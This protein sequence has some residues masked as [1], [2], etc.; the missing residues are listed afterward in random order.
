MSKS[1][2]L[3]ML[4]IRTQ[5]ENILIPSV[6][7][8]RSNSRKSERTVDD[9]RSFDSFGSLALSVSLSAGYVA[10]DH[11][12]SLCTCVMPQTQKVVKGPTRSL[13]S[14]V[15]MVGKN[16][17]HLD[18]PV[19]KEE[20]PSK[21]DILE[22]MLPRA[23][24]NEQ[25]AARK[26]LRL[27]NESDQ[28]TLFN[29]LKSSKAGALVSSNLSV[30]S[31]QPVHYASGDYSAT[32]SV[33]SEVENGVEPRGIRLGSE[34]EGDF[35]PISQRKPSLWATSEYNGMYA[36]EEFKKKVEEAEALAR[37]AEIA[38]AI[39][40]TK[41]QLKEKTMQKVKALN[42]VLVNKIKL[43]DAIEASAANL[44]QLPH[45]RQKR[46][47]G[48]SDYAIQ[49]E[50]L[51][52][53]LRNPALKPDEEID[54]AA[55]ERA[56]MPVFKQ[57]VITVKHN[58][59]DG[60]DVSY[61]SKEL[62][63]HASCFSEADSLSSDVLKNLQDLGASEIK[64][65]LKDLANYINSH[66]SRKILD[67]WH[68]I[69]GRFR[70]STHS[71]SVIEIDANG[72]AHPVKHPAIPLS[73]L[74]YM[75]CSTKIKVGHEELKKMC[76]RLGF[77]SQEQSF[78]AR[79][80][81][82]VQVVLAM[83]D[84]VKSE[85]YE[86]FKQELWHLSKGGE[87]L[88]S[89]QEFTDII[90]PDD[91]VERETQM[92]IIKASRQEQVQAMMDEKKNKATMKHRA[93]A[94]KKQMIDDFTIAL[95]QVQLMRG[96]LTPAKVAEFT[97]M[98]EKC[99]DYIEKQNEDQAANVPQDLVLF[100]GLEAYPQIIQDKII[101][102]RELREAQRKARRPSDASAST[103]NSASNPF[104]KANL[105]N[106]AISKGLGDDG[107]VV[108]TRSN[109]GIAAMAPIEEGS[110]SQ[111]HSTADGAQRPSTVSQDASTGT[112]AG[113]MKVRI[114]A[115]K[116]V[117]LAGPPSVLNVMKE[118]VSFG[119]GLHG[120]SYREAVS[121]L[122]AV[123]AT[124]IT[125]MFR[126]FRKRWRYTAARRMW[127]HRFK[128]VLSKNLNALR[129]LVQH[130]VNTRRLCWRK[131]KAWQFYNKRA[132]ER[133]RTFRIAFWPFYVWHRYANAM[134]KAK[135]KATFLVGRV[136]PAL[137]T[138]KVFKAWKGYAKLEG[139]LNRAADGF[140]KKLQRA[141]VIVLLRWMHEWS[142]KRHAIRRAWNIKGN[143]M[144]LRYISRLVLSPFYTWRTFTNYRM[145][146]RG[147][148]RMQQH[149]MRH[150]LLKNRPPRHTI[151]NSERRIAM[152]VAELKKRAAVRRVSQD[153]L[154][155][156]LKKRA[157]AKK[158][159][160]RKSAMGSRVGSPGGAHRTTESE[161]EDE[162]SVGG[163]RS[164]R[165][166]TR[167]G[168]VAV[169]IPLDFHDAVQ[170]LYRPDFQWKMDLTEMYDVDSDQED[171][172]GLTPTVLT[173]YKKANIR[174]LQ[175]PESFDF[176]VKM[177]DPLCDH[178]CLVREFYSF[179]D[180][181]NSFEASFRFHFFGYRAFKN[182][183]H[184][185]VLRRKVRIFMKVRLQR[186]KK[187]IMNE[188]RKNIE[189][190][191]KRNAT[192][193]G[194]EAERIS[195]GVRAH[196]VAKVVR[197][198]KFTA[199]VNNAL[200]RDH[201]DVIDDEAARLNRIRT[202]N[203]IDPDD[204]EYLEKEAKRLEERQA[205]LKRLQIER[206]KK[207]QPPN[208]LEID[209]KDR[210]LEHAQAEEMVNF[211]KTTRAKTEDLVKVSDEITHGFRDKLGKT[212]AMVKEVLD[213]ES[214]VTSR[215]RERQEA[216]MAQFKVHAAGQLVNKLL[217]VYLEV[218]MSLMK[219]ESKVYFR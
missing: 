68:L 56:Q 21:L 213:S 200:G 47:A 202:L 212:Q 51:H 198:R 99:K 54:Y 101:A 138:I 111:Q 179:A 2:S 7:L 165:T 139:R 148:A 210:D 181:W 128:M 18:L 158:D 13:H 175:D 110:Q 133:R 96:L 8:E 19:Q 40:Q 80:I 25:S 28:Q 218:Q 27:Q 113:A 75:L 189:V 108:S 142:H 131:L 144:R 194:S 74:A 209:R 45:I 149:P 26:R 72:L 214:A 48:V 24:R 183:Q 124:K 97:D 121:V 5:P 11:F 126:C 84:E 215:A 105:A 106:K 46:G 41:V 115:Y 14:P 135:D 203:L 116:R 61:Y 137:T 140:F 23:L 112:G 103:A 63:S 122:Q 69:E 12:I 141:D 176:F 88:V 168:S 123:A 172:D 76:N 42:E 170:A 62:K 32:N 130:N 87:P 107:S 150:A 67:A 55:F 117:L 185:A 65:K 199:E 53:D 190:R 104:S 4:K 17:M 94:R 171:E 192:V 169:E 211:S 98:L 159:A 81:A 92:G 3:P 205:E 164:R 38:G 79:K 160:H 100:L 20:L 146:T 37:S 184:F 182:M 143:E 10:I 119:R 6:K 60:E 219:E 118:M 152:K 49:N 216:Y 102:K 173:T 83:N 64:A 206:D 174:A 201:D 162:S 129:T 161:S 50:S 78:L 86:T 90:F 58:G 195:H 147:R 22:A 120:L 178:S 196:Q 39:A 9:S 44:V 91:P 66:T 1:E 35:V 127:I 89:L 70:S 95:A 77:I 15:K 132:H 217:K 154:K 197:A 85:H 153:E 31:Y 36:R 188:L 33:M 52:M 30:G 177:S 157:K 34:V 134:G 187:Q 204:E 186:I 151:S 93:A 125:A 191:N 180:H 43:Q 193:R 59:E 29:I 208:L 166:S 156:K 114:P 155:D 207:F 167:T 109:G 57:R 163:E 145:I 136:M 16:E 73:A 82:A 71:K